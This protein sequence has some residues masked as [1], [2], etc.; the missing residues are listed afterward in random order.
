MLA[1]LNYFA[2]IVGYITIV[3]LLLVIFFIIAL[4]IKDKYDYRQLAKIYTEKSKELQK[5]I[6]KEDNQKIKIE[7]SAK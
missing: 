1:Y 2:M 4:F 7:V 3:M 6:P 5:E